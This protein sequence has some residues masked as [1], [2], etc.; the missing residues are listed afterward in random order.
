[1]TIV[2]AWRIDTYGGF[3]SQSLSPLL[4]FTS[5][6]YHT[7]P[8]KLKICDSY[9]KWALGLYGTDPG[10][11]LRVALAIAD[12]HGVN[13]K[14]ITPS[15]PFSKT[16]LPYYFQSPGTAVVIALFIRVFGGSCILPYF[17]FISTLNA[18]TALLTYAYS[19]QLRIRENYSL[20]AG[21][22]SL[23]CLPAV[24]SMFGAGLF[25]SEPLA[26]PFVIIALMAISHA[27]RL[28]GQIFF[29]RS[30]PS[31]LIAGTAFALASYMRDV[32]TSFASFSTI[33]G[34]VLYVF[35]S[36]R[37]QRT[38]A[39][40]KSCGFI[41]I[42]FLAFSL[43][44]Y[45]WKKRNMYYFREY[46][47]TSSTYY[48]RSLWQD[49]WTNHH[50]VAGHFKI[51]ESAI[52]LGYFLEPEKSVEILQ[53]LQQNPR[54]G[55]IA[56][57]KALTQ[58]VLIHPLRTV[59]F[60]LRDYD[61]LWFGKRSDYGI[62]AWCLVSMMSFLIFC[63]MTKMNFAIDLYFFPA[64]ILF[65]S[66]LIHYEHR[67]S[68]IFFIFVTPICIAYLVEHFFTKRRKKVSETDSRSSQL[69]SLHS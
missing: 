5:S 6:V 15:E 41:L 68:Q 36:P 13:I 26:A 53:K 4:A 11:Y 56:A 7:D 67:Y 50:D 31:A 44:Q 64:F 46:T 28:D 10:N 1:M 65:I 33:L 57:M 66:P 59:Q 63:K 8:A 61:L 49:M 42:A 22:L 30:L 34:F 25:S 69:V 58:A 12:G 19:K 51:A 20:L 60:K 29:R 18:V 40:K 47:M 35:Q 14:I 45:P 62:Y 54:S 52:G 21:L 3:A 48:A 32:Y 17:L 38:L 2:F 23:T 27:A 39:L 43:I 24:D 16:Y 55:S 37:G 9:Q